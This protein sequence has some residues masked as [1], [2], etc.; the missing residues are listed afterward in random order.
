MIGVELAAAEPFPQAVPVRPDEF[1]F[2]AFFL[3]EA[4]LVGGK[5]RGLAGQAEIADLHLVGAASRPIGAPVAACRQQSATRRQHPT[6]LPYYHGPLP[7]MG[8]RSISQVLNTPNSFMI[9]K[10]SR[11]MSRST[12]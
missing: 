12:W 7:E 2:Q 9:R 6:R 10:T 4:H 5:D 3:V 11:A 8:C 1:N